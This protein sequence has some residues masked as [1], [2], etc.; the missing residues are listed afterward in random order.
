MASDTLVRNYNDA[1]IFT[2]FVWT[3][4]INMYLL[5]PLNISYDVMIKSQRSMIN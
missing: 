4:M 2:G 5:S 1:F 3:S